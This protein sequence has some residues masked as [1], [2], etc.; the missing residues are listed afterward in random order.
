MNNYNKG[1]SAKKEFFPDFYRFVI[2]YF[3]CLQGSFW[4]SKAI[5]V[6]FLLE[7]MEGLV[8]FADLRCRKKSVMARLGL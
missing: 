2:A 3:T 6:F 7:A 1:A 5:E 8:F 4:L